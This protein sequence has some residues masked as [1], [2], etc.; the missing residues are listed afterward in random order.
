MAKADKPTQNRPKTAEAPASSRI[1]LS[2]PWDAGVQV[3]GRQNICTQSIAD[4]VHDAEFIRQRTAV[5]DTY[6]RETQKTRRLGIICAGVLLVVAVVVPLFAPAGR[7]TV[8][9]TISA[10][11]FAFAAGAIGYAE[12]SIRGKGR[13]ISLKGLR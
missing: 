12:A 10:A 8:S 2:P 3:Y 7:E 13:S 4:S 11:L 1:E 6:I 5:H 9:W